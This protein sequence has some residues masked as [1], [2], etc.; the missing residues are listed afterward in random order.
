M[1]RSKKTVALK[2]A[3]KSGVPQP[4]IQTDK[5]HRFPV[6]VSSPTELI[7]PKMNLTNSYGIIG[8]KSGVNADSATYDRKSISPQGEC[9]CGRSNMRLIDRIALM[10]LVMT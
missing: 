3:S 5:I 6:I 10:R 9:F 4:E 1:S 8:A 2:V 7:A